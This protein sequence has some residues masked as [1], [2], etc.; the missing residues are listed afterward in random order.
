[1]SYKGWI[2]GA[3]ITAVTATVPVARAS[4]IFR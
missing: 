2:L 3:G 1:M 4:R